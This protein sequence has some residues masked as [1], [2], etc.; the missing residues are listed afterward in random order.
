MSTGSCLNCLGNCHPTASCY[1]GLLDV[2]RRE[3][4]FLLPSFL[5]VRVL[6]AQAPHCVL[7]TPLGL[8]SYQR[9]QRGSVSWRMSHCGSAKLLSCH[10]PSLGAWGC[11]LQL[12][13]L[14]SPIGSKGA[15]ATSLHW[16]G[17]P[18]WGGWGSGVCTHSS[19]IR[20][21]HWAQCHMIL[22]LQSVKGLIVSFAQGEQQ[23][24]PPVPFRLSSS[25]P[26]PT[27]WFPF[28]QSSSSPTPAPTWSIILSC[29]WGIWGWGWGRGCF[30]RNRPLEA[31]CPSSTRLYLR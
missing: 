26:C 4:E 9:L 28:C 5:G 24:C 31:W 29:Y 6:L 17:Q 30:C 3:R 12:R 21:R 8:R 19:C 18:R 1:L 11:S 16:P 20:W 10:I 13:P 25:S 15:W 22:I 23:S 27:S 14:L 2:R 7:C